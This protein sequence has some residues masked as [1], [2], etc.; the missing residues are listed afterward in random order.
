MIWV[1]VF[2]PLSFPFLIL[3]TLYHSTHS[4]V[5]AYWA[6][7]RLLTQLPIYSAL[8]AFM[9]LLCC[10]NL[11]VEYRETEKSNNFFAIVHVVEKS[12]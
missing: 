1:L 12:N 8:S 5:H 9:L 10:L 7:P 11:H 6:L 3:S 4:V 2:I